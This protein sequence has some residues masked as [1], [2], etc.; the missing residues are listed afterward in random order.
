M[1]LI[2]TSAPAVEPVTV[3][4]VKMACRIID[5]SEDSYL[6]LLISTARRY[7]ETITGRSFITQGWRLTL[8]SFPGPGQMGVPW[9]KAYGIPGHAIV[10]E[11]GPVTAVTSIT[12]IG[13]DGTQQTMPPSDYTWVDSGS[14]A[15]VTPVFGKIWPIPL[16]QIGAV[17]VNY[18]AGFGA[19]ADLVPE[20]VRHWMLVR[21][22]TMYEN[23]EEVAILQRGK[24][25]ALPYVDSL[26]DPIRGAML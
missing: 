5:D 7:G 12:Y 14:I 13:M 15:R 16:P 10:L 17:Q 18:T 25:E 23:R 8:D 4:D 6:S 19:T 22:A 24:V 20:T 26:L 2:Q 9:G 11:R 21:V 1:P 3:A